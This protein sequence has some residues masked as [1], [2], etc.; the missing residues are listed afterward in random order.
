MIKIVLICSGGMSTGMLVKKMNEAA[1]EMN[2][3]C[4]IHA[5]GISDAERVV[6]DANIA[7]LGPQIGFNL[8]KI[9][10]MAQGIPVQVIDHR[11][12]GMMNGKVVLE[13]A[14]KALGE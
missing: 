1:N 5:Y 8:K 14:L 12:Y 10:T 3:E 2:I 9:E 7:L 6:A 13:K 11:D 4:D